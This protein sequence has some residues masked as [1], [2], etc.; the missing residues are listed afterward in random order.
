MISFLYVGLPIEEVLGMI[1]VLRSRLCTLFYL[2]SVVIILYLAVY[3][4]RLFLY[5]YYS[6]SFYIIL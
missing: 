4:I 3:F 2:D 6:V 1:V 5:V